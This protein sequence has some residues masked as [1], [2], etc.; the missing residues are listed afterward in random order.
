MGFENTN[1]R[2]DNVVEEACELCGEDCVPCI[3]EGG[4]LIFNGRKGTLWL[5]PGPVLLPLLYIPY[6]HI[7]RCVEESA[8]S[9]AELRAIVSRLEH[10]VVGEANLKPPF[11]GIEYTSRGT[12]S[13]S[14]HRF[15]EITLPLSA[16]TLPG[17]C[18]ASFSD[19]L[20]KEF[21]QLHP[22]PEK[23]L[24]IASSSRFWVSPRTLDDKAALRRM[25]GIKA[26][27]KGVVVARYNSGRVKG[28]GHVT[29]D[30]PVP[31]SPIRCVFTNG[32]IVSI[33]FK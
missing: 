29:W 22:C 17:G 19:R 33:H 13:T 20:K 5:R 3:Q 26:N 2:E 16:S 18:F 7:S 27:V 28:S 32:K 11:N 21:R 10:G 6:D 25:L 14:P 8:E 1:E 24:P 4:Q 30:R 9:L 31:L 23:E 12:L 15:F